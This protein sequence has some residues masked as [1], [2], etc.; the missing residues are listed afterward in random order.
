MESIWARNI[1]QKFFNKPMQKE[2]DFGG[3]GYFFENSESQ[4]ACPLEL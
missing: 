3:Q 4:L 1:F 2:S